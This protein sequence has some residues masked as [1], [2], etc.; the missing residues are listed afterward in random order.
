M[1]ADQPATRREK[2]STTKAT[3]TTRANVAT[4]MEPAAQQRFGAGAVRGRGDELA[5]H[6]VRGPFRAHVGD[7]GDHPHSPRSLPVMPSHT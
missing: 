4:R 5:I 3:W 2:V 1:A 7:G 6:Q